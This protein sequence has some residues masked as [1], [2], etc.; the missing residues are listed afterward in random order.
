MHLQIEN[1]TPVFAQLRKIS[2]IGAMTVPLNLKI[3][4]S[5]AGWVGVGVVRQVHPLPPHIQR[6]EGLF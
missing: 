2:T 5:D 3:P 6:R 1:A 4:K